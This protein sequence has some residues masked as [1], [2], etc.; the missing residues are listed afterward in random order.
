MS[1]G[2]RIPLRQAEQ[3]AE[4]LIERIRDCCERI[5]VAGS[6]RRRLPTVGDI[7]LVAVPKID[8]Q[9]VIDLFGDTVNSTERDTLADALDSMASHG[10]I[11]RRTRAD[12]KTVWGQK[13]RYLTFEGMNVDLFTPD[14]Q[15]FGLIL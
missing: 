1:T 13:M 5:E 15:R 12:G 7:E 3:S 6:I 8:R 9:P 2:T 10:V 14:A 4:R 11:T